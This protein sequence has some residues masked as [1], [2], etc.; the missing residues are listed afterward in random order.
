[1]ITDTEI[2]IKGVQALTNI[3]GEVDAERFVALIQRE[4]FDYT[5]WQRILWDNMTVEEISKN[6]MKS[7]KEPVDPDRPQIVE[8]KPYP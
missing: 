3:L 7:Y 5:R 2:K 1:M 8:K 6:A 4:P